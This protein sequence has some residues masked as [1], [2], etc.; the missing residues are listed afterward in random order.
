MISWVIIKSDVFKFFQ[1]VYYFFISIFN[2]W[3][4]AIINMIVFLNYFFKN[5]F[6]IK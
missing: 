4:P 1:I 2:K 5:I 6:E 3:M